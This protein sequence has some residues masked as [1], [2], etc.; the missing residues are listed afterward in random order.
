[1]FLASVLCSVVQCTTPNA[2]SVKREQ[3]LA[4]TFPEVD[5]DIDAREYSFPDGEKSDDFKGSHRLERLIF[6]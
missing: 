5:S 2:S 4:N 6:R 1:M 3:V